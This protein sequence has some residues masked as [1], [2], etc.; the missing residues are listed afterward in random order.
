MAVTYKNEPSQPTACRRN[1]NFLLNYGDVD[2]LAGIICAKRTKVNNYGRQYRRKNQGTRY[3]GTG[4][5]RE[6]SCREKRRRGTRYR[7]SP[8]RRPYPAGR[9]S[10]YR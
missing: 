4:K 9:R 5:R 8:L 3:K 7:R 2:S 6:S 10:G 1:V